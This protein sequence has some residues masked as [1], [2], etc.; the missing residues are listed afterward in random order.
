MGVEYGF[1]CDVL[2]C[3]VDKEVLPFTWQ[4]QIWIHLEV[5]SHQPSLK[6]AV[7]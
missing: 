1:T 2:Q 4:E 3:C 5:L 7:K 6:S